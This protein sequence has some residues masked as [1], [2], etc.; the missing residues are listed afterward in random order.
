MNTISL[1]QAKIHFLISVYIIIV[2]NSNVALTRTN[3]NV[4]QGRELLAMT[5]VEIQNC[6]RTQ[7]ALAKNH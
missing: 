1:M 4:V 2:I 3:K 6:N 7:I 5:R